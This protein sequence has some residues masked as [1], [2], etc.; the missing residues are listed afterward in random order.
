MIR[1]LLPILLLL[2][3]STASRAQGAGFAGAPSATT[4]CRAAIA[5]AERE[6]GLPTGLL[7]AIGRVESG[8]RDPATGEFGPY[9]WTINAE[10]QG[11]FFPSKAEAIAEVRQLQAGGMRLIDVG[12]MQI[13]LHHHRDAFGSLEEAFDPLT[14][15]RYAARFLSNLQAT[16]GD[17]MV[18]AGNYHSNTPERAAMYRAAVASR[19]A[20]GQRDVAGAPGWNPGWNGAGRAPVTTAAGGMVSRSLPF[21]G[22]TY[23]G[24]PATITRVQAQG[25]EAGGERGRGLGAYRAM[26]I[27]MATRAPVVAGGRG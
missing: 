11:K 4:L 1:L 22:S 2:L 6:Y 9:P 5:T 12:C 8:R 13:N 19:M 24:A 21:A 7:A 26:P 3:L 27:P 17:W 18:S 10:G 23:A 20:E 25:G 14:N 15:A 16:R